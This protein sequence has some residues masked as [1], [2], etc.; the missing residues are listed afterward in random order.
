MPWGNRAITRLPDPVN[1]AF[2]RNQEVTGRT[3][4]PEKTRWTKRAQMDWNALQCLLVSLNLALL[5]TG[6]GLCV[7]HMR[8]GVLPSSGLRLFAVLWLALAAVASYERR[9]ARSGK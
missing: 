8:R 3:P 1:L 9:A 5:G 4:V 2:L 6:I 7:E